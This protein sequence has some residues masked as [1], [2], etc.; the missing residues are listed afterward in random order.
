[1]LFIVPA[2]LT[3]MLR[4]SKGARLSLVSSTAT[5]CLTQDKTNNYRRTREHEF[6]T[7]RDE[8]WD[9]LQRHGIGRWEHLQLPG[10]GNECREEPERIL[11]RGECGDRFAY[12]IGPHRSR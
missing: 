9:K 8:H 6:C 12:E 10:P 7:G 3:T 2:L 4:E 11:R 1:L 5:V